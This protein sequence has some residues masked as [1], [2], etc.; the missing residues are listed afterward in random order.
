MRSE[1][2]WLACTGCMLL[3]GAGTFVFWIIM[4]IDCFR[5]DEDEFPNPTDNTKTTWA[6][7]LLVSWLV[8]LYWLAAIVYFFLVRRRMPRRKRVM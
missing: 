8:W 7:V 5:R 3:F 2:L 6:L 1:T 4:L